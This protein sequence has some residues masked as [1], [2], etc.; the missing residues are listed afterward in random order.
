[1]YFIILIQADVRYEIC[2][3]N[4]EYIYTIDTCT[5]TTWVVGTVYSFSILVISPREKVLWRGL[6]SF[7]CCWCSFM[8]QLTFN[9]SQRLNSLSCWKFRWNADW[10]LVGDIFNFPPSLQKYFPVCVFLVP[11]FFYQNTKAII[12]HPEVQFLERKN[13]KYSIAVQLQET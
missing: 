11:C 1:M 13:I 10:K 9:I 2:D 3:N 5:T 12:F 8:L 6:L 7:F 4:G